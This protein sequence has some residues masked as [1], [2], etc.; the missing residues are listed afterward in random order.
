[1]APTCMSVL[2]VDKQ[3]VDKQSVRLAQ[4]LIGDAKLVSIMAERGDERASLF[5]L[6]IKRA[7]E[8]MQVTGLTEA[9]R[10]GRLQDRTLMLLRM[11][12]N[13]MFMPASLPGKINGLSKQIILSWLYNADSRMQLLQ[14]LPPHC[15]ALFNERSISSDSVELVFAM[16]VMICGYKPPMSTLLGCTHNIEYA[17]RMRAQPPGTRPFSIAPSEMHTYALHCHASKPEHWNDGRSMLG[18]QGQELDMCRTVQVEAT[19]KTEQKSA[20]IRS[21]FKAEAR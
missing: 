5:L 10:M 1:M 14:Q 13:L 12:G 6:V 3:S 17:V 20:P 8:A 15:R 7:Y 11:V 16:V 2:H 21:F 4:A 18:E 9:V 19:R